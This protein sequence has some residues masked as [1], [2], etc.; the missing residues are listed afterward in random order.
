MRT[1]CAGTVD[2]RRSRPLHRARR[3]VT[4]VTEI[5]ERAGGLTK[6]TF[7]RHFTDKREVLFA[8]QAS[9]SSATPSNAGPTSPA[10]KHS[11]PSPARHDLA[12]TNRPAVH[13]TL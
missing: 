3:N 2:P 4:T 9:H 5:A 8:A 12:A 13:V 7:F 10:G 11:S 6:T 1:E